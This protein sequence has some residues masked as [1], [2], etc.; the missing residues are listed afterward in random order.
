MNNPCPSHNDLESYFNG[1][2]SA[3]NL[4]LISQHILGCEKCV[5]IIESIEATAPKPQIQNLA[6][7]NV[8]GGFSSKN[9]Q[10]ILD[11]GVYLPEKTHALVER[12]LVANQSGQ[13]VNLNHFR[14][15]G[16]L[17]MGSSG[18]VFEALDEKLNRKVAIKVMIHLTSNIKM[19]NRS[20][21]HEAKVIAAV[22]HEALVEI[23]EIGEWD[24]LQFIVMPFLAGENL[25]TRLKYNELKPFM[26]AQAIPIAIQIAQGLKALHETRILH[27]DLKPSNIWLSK[28]KSDRDNIIILDLGLAH[29]LD[30]PINDGLYC[31]TLGYMSPEQTNGDTLDVRS[32]LFTFGCVLFEMLNGKP[33]FSFASRVDAITYFRKEITPDLRLFQDKIPGTLSSLVRSLM[34]VNR[35]NRPA[36]I[37]EVI[38]QLKTIE[39]KL[40]SPPYSRRQVILT[41]LGGSLLFSAGLFLLYKQVYSSVFETN[42]D[43]LQ[44]QPLVFKN[45]DKYFLHPSKE[46]VGIA[47][48]S[49]VSFYENSKLINNLTLSRT[50][51]KCFFSDCGDY[52]CFYNPGTIT[53]YSYPELIKIHQIEGEPIISFGFISKGDPKKFFYC[54]RNQ[55]FFVNLDESHKVTESELFPVEISSAVSDPRG[56]GVIVVSNERNGSIGLVSSVSLKISFNDNGLKDYYREGISKDLIIQTSFC[57]E[58]SYAAILSDKGYV[59]TFDISK[60]FSPLNE[61]TN[62][63]EVR[64]IGWKNKEILTFLKDQVVIQKAKPLQILK[65]NYE[66]L[67]NTGSSSLKNL[68]LH[69]ED[70][71]LFVWNWK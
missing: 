14:L 56:R 59:S 41:V 31:G 55:F 5:S 51:G 67:I 3:H 25:A 29:R 4:E 33:P 15:V 7:P 54:N 37:A 38:K 34:E 20:F 44:N 2:L 42:S 47:Q 8:F 62:E 40:S 48:G 45:V 50:P 23:Y 17:G 19:Q 52:L 66:S 1:S 28:E 21:D 35:E 65:S 30:T 24:N 12:V 26:P 16:L 70:K 60:F 46:I 58:E 9:L 63:S 64:N 57:S 68:A 43:V 49:Q 69:M 71:Q 53:I 18:I 6:S 13:S 22:K 11:M 27:R 32:D 10:K 39:K 36:T 61:Y